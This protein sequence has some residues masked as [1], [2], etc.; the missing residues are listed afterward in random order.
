MLVHMHRKKRAISRAGL[1]I[2]SLTT[3][4]TY[5][6]EHMLN[7]NGNKNEEYN[8]CGWELPRKQLKTQ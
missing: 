3:A 7:R 6:A 8:V 1:S 4:T 5:A 2:G